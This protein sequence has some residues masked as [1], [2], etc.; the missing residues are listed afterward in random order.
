LGLF[1]A[2]IGYSLTG[3][4][5]EQ[6]V[7]LCWGEGSNGKSTFLEVLR[8]VFGTYA[9]NLPFSAFELTG[10]SSIPNDIAPLVGKRFVTAIETND[11]VR[12]NEARMKALTG[13]DAIT[14]RFMYREFFT[15]RPVCKIW[16][17]FNHKPIVTDDFHGFWRRIRLIPFKA[18]F[19]GTDID[20]QMI[21]K[22]MAEATG[23]LSW[24]VRGCLRWQ[25]QGLGMPSTVTDA[26]TIYRSES[27]PLRDFLD[28][29]CT[30]QT[31]GQIPVKY[32]WGRYMDWVKENNIR[33]P[34]RR[35]Q[36]SERLEKLGA[37]KLRFGHDR[38]WT[39]FGISLSTDAQALPLESPQDMRTDAD[40]RPQ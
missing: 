20:S 25:A 1:S 33:T 28:D 31:D 21:S 32:L 4:N 11:A 34:L 12:L 27:D 35:P 39:W 6:C 14:A 22:L 15:F 7:F 13:E 26:T 30:L 19:T 29:C 38:T 40:V 37:Q 9:H 18:A 5:R 16:L 2:L 36:F 17:A 8:N 24:G 3:D 10:R 23:I